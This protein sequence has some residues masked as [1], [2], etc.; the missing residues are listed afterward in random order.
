MKT[1][2]NICG[3]EVDRRPGYMKGNHSIYCSREC[4]KV[5]RSTGKMCSCGNCGKEVYRSQAELSKS[6]SGNIFCSK[7][8]ST[9]VNN[10]LTKSGDNNANWVNGISSY[11]KEAFLVYNPSCTICGFTE[12]SALQVHR[13]DYDRTNNDIDNL[14]ILCANHHCMVHYGSL[15]IS[16]DIKSSREMLGSKPIT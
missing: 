16:E 4:A 8:C 10:H 15:V 7:S 11:V 14:I 13:I 2:C 12:R 9:T 1:N 5:G 3:K 6:K